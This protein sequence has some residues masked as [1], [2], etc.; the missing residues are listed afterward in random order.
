MVIK[1]DTPMRHYQIKRWKFWFLLIAVFIF[2]AIIGSSEKNTAPKPSFDASIYNAVIDVDNGVFLVL[3]GMSRNL[4]D[5]FGDL[6]KGDVSNLPTYLSRQKAV[7]FQLQ[8]LR[9][10][11]EELLRKLGYH[12]PE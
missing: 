3:A 11:R 7:N 10:K 8:T 5:L 4:Q 9:I 6:S 2:G 1:K 12:I